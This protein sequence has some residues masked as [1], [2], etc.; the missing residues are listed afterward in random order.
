MPNRIYSICTYSRFILCFFWSKSGSKL[1]RP[2]LAVTQCL[3]ICVTTK[4]IFP[5][6]DM[7]KTNK[8]YFALIFW[9]FVY[10]SMS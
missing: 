1:F 3:S 8:K 5:N 9:V 6:V 2:I 10:L 7:Q 4:T